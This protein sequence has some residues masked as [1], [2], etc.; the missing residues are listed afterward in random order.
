M[1]K[2]ASQY[3]VKYIL[4]GGNLSTECIR[5]PID[6]MYFQSDSRQLKDIQKIN[7]AQKI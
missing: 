3:N 5:N 1:Y 7:L 6:W 4:T 2:F